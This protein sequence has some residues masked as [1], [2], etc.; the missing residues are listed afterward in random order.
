MIST[1]SEIHLILDIQVRFMLWC[2]SRV[3]TNPDVYRA[4]GILRKKNIFHYFVPIIKFSR[5]MF[6]GVAEQMSNLRKF[7][8]QNIIFPPNFQTF[9][10]L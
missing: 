1:H 4:T 5:R 2:L 3:S 8:P 10:P 6:G 7:S 9:L